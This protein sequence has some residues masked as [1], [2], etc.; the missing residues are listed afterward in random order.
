MVLRFIEGRTS[1]RV[2]SDG[3]HQ[4]L[5]IAKAHRVAYTWKAAPGALRVL[6]AVMSARVICAYPGRFTVVVFIS[7]S[8]IYWLD[9]DRPLDIARMLD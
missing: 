2:F 5:R 7:V 1:P 3:K 8:W 4:S 6:S 9:G